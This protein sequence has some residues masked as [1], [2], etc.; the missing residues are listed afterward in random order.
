MRS[1][2]LRATQRLWPAPSAPPGY[3]FLRTE[4]HPAWLSIAKAQLTVCRPSQSSSSVPFLRSPER[5][6]THSQLTPEQLKAAHL[7]EDLIRL[8][9][10]IESVDDIIADL[11]QALENA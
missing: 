11:D 3:V 1:L 8:S 5:A 6:T 7:T 9:V 4:E 10:G 2:C